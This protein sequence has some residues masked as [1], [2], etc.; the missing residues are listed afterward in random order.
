MQPKII[1]LFSIR[2]KPKSLHYQSFKIVMSRTRTQRFPELVGMSRT[3]S[4]L[5]MML[6]G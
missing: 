6:E 5:L 2:E 3:G 1:K 4:S